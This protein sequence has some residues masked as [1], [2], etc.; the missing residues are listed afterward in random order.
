M[1]DQGL[2]SHSTHKVNDWIMTS[3]SGRG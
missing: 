1:V 2:T 3:V